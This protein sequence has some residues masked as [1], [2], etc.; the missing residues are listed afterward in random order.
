MPA[1][2][3]NAV[4]RRRIQITGVVQGVGFRPYIYRL[5][6]ECGLVGQVLNDSAGVDIEVQGPDSSLSTFI[7]RLLP[8]A[9]PLSRIVTF[10]VCDV[11]INGD[12]EF[13]IVKSHGTQ[14]QKVLISP[15]VAVCADCLREIF[16]TADRRYRYPFI[17]CTNCGPRF[18]IV[19]D[20]PYD[21]PLTSMSVFP[22]CVGLPERV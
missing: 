1:Q 8:E 7:S 12:Q 22:M 15:D 2:S 4:V 18:T 9:P 17:N 19:R 13:R 16:D 6:H 11:P 21:R 3:Q 20:I 10:D 5:A 14:E